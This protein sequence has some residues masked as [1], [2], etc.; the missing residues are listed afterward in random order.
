MIKKQGRR[1]KKPVQ[2]SPLLSFFIAAVFGILADFYF[3]LGA[4]FWTSTLYVS[5]G[6]FLLTKSFSFFFRN[7]PIRRSLRTFA[8]TRLPVVGTWLFCATLSGGL[9]L[10]IGTAALAGLR[11]DYYYNYFPKSEIGLFIPENGVGAVVEFYVSKTPT[12]IEFEEGAR[13]AYGDDCSTRLTGEI[14]RVKNRG[15]WQSCS[16]KVAV[17]ITGDATR[18]RVGDFVRAAGRLSRPARSSNP[19]E[20]DQV[21]YYRSQRILSILRVNS[22]DNVK[23]LAPVKPTRR[24]LLRRTLEQIR[25]NAA[26]AVRERLSERNAS[27][28]V[29]MTLGFRNDV[30]EETHE[31]F[32]RTGTVHLLAISGLHVMLV[33]GAI[34]FLL[35]AI[36][37]PSEAVASI[38]LVFVFLYLGLTDMR[39]P[40]IR[41]TVLITIMCLGVL[42]QRQGLMLNSLACAALVLLAINPCELFQ[43]GAQLSFLA[44]GTFLWSDSATIFEKAASSTNR[45]EAVK[46]RRKE[47]KEKDEP[48]RSFIN[49]TFLP[50]WRRFFRYSWAKV[51]G[52]TLTG[53]LIWAV[54]A[55]LILSVTNLFTPVAIIANPLIWLP[56]TLSLLLSFLLE[57]CGL[58]ANLNFAPSFFESVLSVLGFITE[59]SFD[60]FLGVLDALSTSNLGVYHL[61]SPPV[62]ALW[63]FYG[64]LVLLTIFPRLRPKR[65]YIVAFAVVWIGV[66]LIAWSVALNRERSKEA[67]TVDVFSV[68]HG[69]AVLGRFA[70]G[71]VFLYDC[72]SLENS[73]RAAEVVAKN[74]WNSGRL[75]IDVVVLSHADFDHFGGM[76]MLLDLVPVRSVCVSPAMFK[77]ENEL[78]ISL[79]KKLENL[80]VRIEDISAG[81]SLGFLGFPELTALHPTLD[82]KGET[83]AE[84]NK[85]SVVLKIDF[86]GRSLLLPGDLDSDEAFFLD[87]PRQKCDFI[88]APHH[89]GRSVNSDAL[90]EW[91]DPDYVGISGGGF[92]RSLVTEDALRAEGRRV[93]HTVDDGDIQITIERDSS[94][95]NVRGRFKASTYKSERSSTEGTF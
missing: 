24:L 54:G 79:H 74:L 4:S 50:L 37:L 57:F 17:S 58:L 18:L 33:V 22:S 75:G 31:K 5:V 84:S 61:P 42:L 15:V 63:L 9:W 77:K 46:G 47:K 1:D 92:L 71:R 45:W 51:R 40:V 90:Y 8:S 34:A 70:D 60:L 44:T 55:P 76:D 69:C 43:P 87:S 94:M 85:N 2:Y 65:R 95:K 72:G 25:L 56:A 7:A 78:T 19:C 32:R 68:G 66:A 80:G 49:R 82:D 64:P 26:S 91:S 93:A 89:G 41:A 48:R 23:L 29:G 28:A 53:A 88:L 20:R 38:T 62:W 35:R 39:P 16:G 67:L 11:H 81:Q 13:S 12:L 10:W 52:V 86:L 21:F 27:V 83:T 3:H 14:L 36:G 30:D 73:Q 59:K 6:A